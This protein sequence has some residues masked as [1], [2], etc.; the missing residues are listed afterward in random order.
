MKKIWKTGR[1]KI[2]GNEIVGICVEGVY[3][4]FPSYTGL[5]GLWGSSFEE[6]GMVGSLT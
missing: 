4:R 6:R 2:I 3:L 5:L 1:K